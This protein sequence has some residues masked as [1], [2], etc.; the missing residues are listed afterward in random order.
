[1]YHRVRKSPS[2]NHV[3]IVSAFRYFCYVVLAIPGTREG[4]LRGKWTLVTVKIQ[5]IQIPALFTD[6]SWWP[7]FPRWVADI[8]PPWPAAGA[9]WPARRSA[10][11]LQR[12]QQLH[13]RSCCCCCYSLRRSLHKGF[14]PAVLRIHD[15]LVWVR[16]RILLFSSLTFKKPTKKSLKKLFVY[17][18]L[19][20]HLHHFSK[21]KS[22]KSHKI[23][24]NKVF[25]YYF[26]MMI[27][28]SGSESG[29]MPLTNGS[30]SG[31]H[32]IMLIRNTALLNVLRKISYGCA[33]ATADAHFAPRDLIAGH[34]VSVNAV[35]RRQRLFSFPMVWGA[36]FFG[37]TVTEFGDRS[38]GWYGCCV[39]LH[40]STENGWTLRLRLLG[41]ATFFRLNKDNDQKTD[42][43]FLL[44]GKGNYAGHS[45]AN[46]AYF[47]I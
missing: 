4:H 36:V 10:A 9:P 15:I 1:M 25:F 29:S 20:V 12:P 18:F 33:A 40:S 41:F 47:Q 7:R 22:Q 19:K 5:C 8:F 39:G 32:K 28:G 37:P 43:C 6:L 11:P 42:Q 31:R 46:V 17:Y 26:C 34:N 44:W 27:E 14:S 23:V 16:I 24:G 13:S 35:R 21:I 3:F 30:G 45:F 2:P 38:L